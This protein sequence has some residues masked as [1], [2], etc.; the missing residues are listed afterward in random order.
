MSNFSTHTASLPHDGYRQLL[1]CWRF[2]LS[3]AQT[4]YWKEVRIQRFLKE[5]CLDLCHNTSQY[6]TTTFPPELLNIHTH[7]YCSCNNNR[8]TRE[9]QTRM[10]LA[11]L[12]CCSAQSGVMSESGPRSLN[13]TLDRMLS[14]PGPWGF[15]YLHNTSNHCEDLH[16]RHPPAVALCWV[17]TGTETFSKSDFLSAHPIHLLSVFVKLS[18]GSVENHDCRSFK[19]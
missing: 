15:L 18:P 2:S 4:S 16:V 3:P 12:R 8:F 13:K 11:H 7:F 17:L 1:T 10:P 6:K 19:K 14:P 5:L 9:T